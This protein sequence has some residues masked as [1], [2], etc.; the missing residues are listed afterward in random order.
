MV[1]PPAQGK[2]VWL[3]L[4]AV[5]ENYTLWINGERISDNLGAGTTMW[6]RPVSAEITGKFTQGQPTHIVVRVTNTAF[7]GGVWKPV[8][9]LAER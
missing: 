3:Q 7:A 2:R 1:I 4:G 5:D 6:D 9:I 8:R